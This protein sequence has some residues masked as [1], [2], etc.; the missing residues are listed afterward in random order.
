MRGNSGKYV[1]VIGKVCWAYLNQGSYSDLVTFWSV[2][3]I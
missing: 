1:Q 2:F 3:N